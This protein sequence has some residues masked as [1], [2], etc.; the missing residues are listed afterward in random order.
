[1]AR[2]E[3]SLTGGLA[4]CRLLFF[5]ECLID[6]AL[7]VERAGIDGVEDRLVNGLSVVVADA[8]ED[9]VDFFG[10]MALV[11]EPGDELGV[12]GFVRHGVTG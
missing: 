9:L 7:D 1:M 4:P 8:G 2:T 6:D 3:D 11:F 12:A 10:G 5:C